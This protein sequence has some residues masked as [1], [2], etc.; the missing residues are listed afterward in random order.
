MDHDSVKQSLI[1]ENDDFRKLFEEHQEC[2][3]KLE[4]L[5][6]KDS[7]SPDDEFEAKKIKVHKLALKDQ[8]EQMIRSHANA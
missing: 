8:M 3:G 5:L 7:P 4:A 6:T 2:E 1:A